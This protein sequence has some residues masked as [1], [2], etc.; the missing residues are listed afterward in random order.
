MA[1]A[2]VGVRRIIMM[3]ECVS[4]ASGPLGQAGL[5]LGIATEFGEPEWKCLSESGPAAAARLPR[6]GLGP[7]PGPAAV[8]VTSTELRVGGDRDTGPLLEAG[9]AAGGPRAAERSH[10][11]TRILLL[12]IIRSQ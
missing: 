7:G 11:R 9:A 5:P 8:G 10:Q 4:V 1:A 12:A 2:G 6:L 3:G